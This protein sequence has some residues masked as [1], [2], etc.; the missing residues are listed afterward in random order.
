MRKMLNQEEFL[1]KY[2]EIIKEEVNVKEIWS[3]QNETPITKVFKPIGSQLSAKF[4]KDTGQIIS[5]GKQGNIR[6]LGEGKVEVFSPQWGSWILDAS[7]YEIA[8]EGLD[9][10]DTAVEGNMIA[11]LDLQITPELE[12][13]G[14]AREISRFLNQMRKD[15]DFAIEQKVRLTYTTTSEY[16][17]AILKE[18]D[19]M[20]KWEALL[21]MIEEQEANGIISSEFVSWNERVYF[22]LA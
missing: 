16:L 18:F 3:F 13:E 15:A 12:R 22:T 20:L 9:A 10:H 2:G 7:D 8:Y 14:V 17:R 4:G 11:K 1:Q 19:Q 5:N 6:E 21:L